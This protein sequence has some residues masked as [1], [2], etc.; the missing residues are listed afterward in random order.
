MA[1]VT[2]HICYKDKVIGY[3]VLRNVEHSPK[4][5]KDWI[6]AWHGSKKENVL[7]IFRIGL[8]K[9]GSEVDGKVLEEK[10][11]H[12]RRTEPHY[13]V[14]NWGQ[15]IFVTDQVTYAA[16]PCYAGKLA[17]NGNGQ[18]CIL[19]EVFVRPESFKKY[20]STVNEYNHLQGDDDKPEMRIP[21][22]ENELMFSENGNKVVRVSE[23]NNVVVFSATLLLDD[24]I[25]NSKLSSSELNKILDSF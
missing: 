20:E 19:F 6:H 22:S 2:S 11:N 17:T 18:W 23:G 14:E 25:L 9:A 13:E 24:F 4:I 21:D 1:F 15:A 10:D 12:W 16:H 7:S 3:R 8:R 5:F